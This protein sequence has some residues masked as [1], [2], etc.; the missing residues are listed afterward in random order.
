MGTMMQLKSDG[1]FGEVSSFGFVSADVRKEYLTRNREGMFFTVG[2]W[3][4]N[5]TTRDKYLSYEQ[6]IEE[7]DRYSGWFL[8]A[9]HDGLALSV[10]A[11]SANDMW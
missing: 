1:T 5:P 6:A 9:R 11:Y 3:F 10:T 2:L 4:R 7:L 8:E